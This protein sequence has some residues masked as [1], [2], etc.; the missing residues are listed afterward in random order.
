MADP[1]NSVPAA[2]LHYANPLTTPLP[3]RRA[4]C[5][6]AFIV[7][8]LSMGLESTIGLA[9]ELLPPIGGN[10]GGAK[11]RFL[12]FGFAALLLLLITGIVLGMLGLT[13]GSDLRP[14]AK[15]ALQMSGFGFFCIIFAA[16]TIRAGP[17]ILPA[18]A[19]LWSLLNPGLLVA[20][21]TSPTKSPSRQ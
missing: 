7:A 17:L 18:I 3:R 9:I 1:P 15:R 10:D 2:T 8:L 5:G 4:C 11:A 14:L 19:M 16:T 13:G 12:V 6:A 20:T 21:Q